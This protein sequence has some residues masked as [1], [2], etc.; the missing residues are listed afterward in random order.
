[1]DIRAALFAIHRGLVEREVE[2]ALIG[3]FALAAHGAGRGSVSLDWIADG[4][5]V[6]VID[7]LLRSSGYERVHLTHNVGNYVSR[8]PVTGRIDF[9]F[10]RR[11]R[12]VA[13]LRRAT[14]CAVFGETV[15]V[16]DASDLIGLKVQAYSNNPSRRVRDLA[17]VD[18]LL[19]FGEV[20]LAR[21]R[22][23]FRLFDR[24]QDLDELLAARAM[25]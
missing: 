8:D 18:R 9:L 12:G 14:E 23:Y 13:I 3:G 5:R 10:V 15:R 21:V 19:E 20:D 17:D 7:E 11:E 1:M 25:R 6:D 22:D 24:E 4:L 16:V 2:H